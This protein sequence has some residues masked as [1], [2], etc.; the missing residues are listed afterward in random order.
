MLAQFTKAKLGLK[1]VKL[2][3]KMI[4]PLKVERDV[5]L[6][7]KSEQVERRVFLYEVYICIYVR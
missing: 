3:E 4:Q 6:D 5:T 7:P 2:I 1:E